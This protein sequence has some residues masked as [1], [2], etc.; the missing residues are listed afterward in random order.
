MEILIFIAVAAVVLLTLGING[1]AIMKGFVLLLVLLLAFLVGFFVLSAAKLLAAKR[2]KGEFVRFEK[3][4]N[5]ETAVYKIDGAEYANLF[6][7][8]PVMRGLI[9][10][11]GERTLF[12]C[13]G[14]KQKPP[15]TIDLHSA[16]II[17]AGFSLSA[18]SLFLVVFTIKVLELI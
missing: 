10:R 13:R 3:N 7:A 12:L 6:P 16:L 5:F 15:R 18:V 2:C 14:R 9:Y 17:A 11:P 4:K 1:F 8:E